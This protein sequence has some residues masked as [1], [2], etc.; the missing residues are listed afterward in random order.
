MRL[1]ACGPLVRNTGPPHIR[2]S[3]RTTTYATDKIFVIVI[4]TTIVLKEMNRHRDCL[5]LTVV[6]FANDG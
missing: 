5:V 3:Y 4:C 6:M 2:P 1:Q